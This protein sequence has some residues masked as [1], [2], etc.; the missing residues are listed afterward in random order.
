VRKPKKRVFVFQPDI[1]E[2]AF[3]KKKNESLKERF[4][5]KGDACSLQR[6]LAQSAVAAREI[7]WGWECVLFA[8]GVNKA[9][10]R[11]REG[12]G[13]PVI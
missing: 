7:G 9:G 1:R 8:R 13:R 2:P 5:G 4:S 10:S 6:R 3:E 12:L 11:R